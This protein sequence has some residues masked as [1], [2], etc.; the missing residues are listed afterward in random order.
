MIEILKN[1]FFHKD[2]PVEKKCFFLSSFC[3]LFL[4]MSSIVFSIIVNYDL[5]LIF[6]ILICMILLV[7]N[8]Y[9][10]EVTGKYFVCSLVMLIINNLIALPVVYILNKKLICGITL[11]MIAG[12]VMCLTTLTGISMLIMSAATAGIFIT[13]VTYVYLHWG[14]Q[15]V[16]NTP[17]VFVEQ[18]FGV[19]VCGIVS[20]I[21]IKCRSVF[22][23][24][25]RLN[26]EAAGLKALEMDERKNIFLANMSHEIRT[27]MNAILGTSQLLLDSDIKPQSKI[28]LFNIINACNA[29]ISTMADIL[30]F[31]HN[32]KSAAAALEEEYSPAELFETIINTENVR[33]MDK[34]IDFLVRLP[35]EFPK[36]L[37]GDMK[38]LRREIISAFNEALQDTV[39]FIRLSVES[40]VSKTAKEQYKSYVIRVTVTGDANQKSF[41]VV[42]KIVET[43]DVKK[44]S[45]I[46]DYKILCFE[47]NESC[48]EMLAQSFS[49][50]GNTPDFVSSEAELWACLHEKLYTYLFINYR[51][52]V[53]IADRLK[54]ALKGI[55]LV[56]IT[57]IREIRVDDSYGTVLTRP[58]YSHNLKAVFSGSSHSSLHRMNI[59]GGF[60]CPGVKVMAVDDNATNLQV[61]DA[62][63]SQYDIS[64]QKAPG[65]EEC[66]YMLEQGEVDLIFMDYMMPDMDGVDTLRAIRAMNSEWAKKVPVIVLTANAV[67]G[68]KEQLLAEG[69]DEYMSKPVEIRHLERMLQKFLPEEKVVITGR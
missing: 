37:K 68:V 29:L 45:D 32:G 40:E 6:T 46:S 26:A 54:D 14:N 11:Y 16:M 59:S 65:G 19:L 42:H 43:G 3:A 17:K 20:G 38:Q 5:T 63:L 12:F 49:Q 56:V 30:E 67:G 51:N 33:F 34:N 47:K 35:A 1:R 55:R 48:E 8:I 44:I 39:N 58:V 31:S 66:I 7:G 21:C 57:D 64:C 62:I 9:F 69:F 53:E 22:F 27:P 18:L 61:L 25:E 52:Y 13:V 28:Y 2:F 24:Q 10:A 50:L 23:E 15:M 60:K 4:Y 36:V 41:S